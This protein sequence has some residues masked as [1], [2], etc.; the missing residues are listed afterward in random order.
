M[1]RRN[2]GKGEHAQRA[3]KQRLQLRVHGVWRDRLGLGGLDGLVRGHGQVVRVDCV[4]GGGARVVELEHLECLA[5]HGSAHDLQLDVG[6]DVDGRRGGCVG[7][8]GG[9]W[10]GSEGELEFAAQGGPFDGA[11]VVL[12]EDE[13][14][15]GGAQERRV[16]AEELG[17]A[18][19]D[20]AGAGG[21]GG[22]DVVVGQLEGGGDG[23]GCCVVPPCWKGSRRGQPCW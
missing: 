21:F 3:D 13:H 17:F 9:R 14:E 12:L 15:R 10:H 5:K 8:R 2:R 1:L 20:G 6:R 18:R 7:R 11:E 4:L 16:G 22:R 23:G 19:L